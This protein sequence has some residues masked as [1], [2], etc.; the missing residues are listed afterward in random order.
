MQHERV[1]NKQKY[2]FFV[3]LSLARVETSMS[4][5][6]YTAIQWN[7]DTVKRSKLKFYIFRDKGDKSGILYPVIEIKI[8]SAL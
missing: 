2:F 7:E 1:E 4:R 6:I 5:Y 3:T 8:Y